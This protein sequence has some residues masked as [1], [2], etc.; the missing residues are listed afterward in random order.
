MWPQTY[1]RYLTTRFSSKLGSS[2]EIHFLRVLV[3][4]LVDQDVTT[5]TIFIVTY[6]SSTSPVITIR[7]NL[8]FQLDTLTL[9][10]VDIHSLIKI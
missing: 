2:A 6:L 9:G 10:L 4:V 1:T 7:I 8:L 3:W 5:D